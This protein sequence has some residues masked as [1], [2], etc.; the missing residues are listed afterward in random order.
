MVLSQESIENLKNYIKSNNVVFQAYGE[1]IEVA[2]DEH[3]DERTILLEYVN[4]ASSV[5][6]YKKGDPFIQEPFEDLSNW[7]TEDDKLFLL[8]TIGVLVC[9]PSKEATSKNIIL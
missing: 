8:E 3:V 2:D 4:K 1:L 9:I 5:E 6:I 7:S